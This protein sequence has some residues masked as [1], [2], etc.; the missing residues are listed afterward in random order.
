MRTWDGVAN[1]V[2]G[3]DPMPVKRQSTANSECQARTKAG[4]PCAAPAIHGGIYCALHSDPQRAAEPGRKGGRN[5]RRTYETDGKEV[6]SPR[7]ASAVKEMLAEIMAEIRAGRLNPKLGTTLAYLGTSLLKAIEISDLEARGVTSLHGKRLSTCSP[8]NDMF[9]GG[10]V[11][12]CP[13]P[14]CHTLA[15][16]VFVG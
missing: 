7:S 9:V 3:G 15:A 4:A 11:L 2:G 12:R 13:L 6:S 8:Q 16:I 14:R 10:R 1:D 5:N